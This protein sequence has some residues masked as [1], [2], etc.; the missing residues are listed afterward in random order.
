MILYVVSVF[1]QAVGAFGRP[2]FVPATGQA[3]R[4]FSDE[5]NSSPPNSDLSKHPEDFSLYALGSYDDLS[6]SFSNLSKPEL[7][8]TG[9]AAVYQKGNGNVSQ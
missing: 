6:G 3:V 9:K 5:V 7:I 8:I 4:S 1:D 2:I